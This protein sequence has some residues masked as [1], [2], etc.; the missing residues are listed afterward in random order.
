MAPFPPVLPLPASLLSQ[1]SSPGEGGVLPLA[2]P[3][4]PQQQ[5]CRVQA[6]LGGGDRVGQPSGT[7]RELS[8]SYHPVQYSTV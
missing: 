5:P 6:G 7:Y 3:L 1:V 2:Q 8:P 4:Q